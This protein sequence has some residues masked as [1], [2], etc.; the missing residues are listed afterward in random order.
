VADQS[1]RAEVEELA[2]GGLL[3]RSVTPVLR[4]ID[5]ADPSMIRAGEIRG[6]LA[7]IRELDL[8]AIACLGQILTGKLNSL[9]GGESA[10]AGFLRALGRE[11]D[12]R[13]EVLTQSLSEAELEAERDRLKEFLVAWETAS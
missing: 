9:S 5:S 7:A 6:L 13:L 12:E 1:W 8:L 11:I 10:E 3:P 4:L 2:A